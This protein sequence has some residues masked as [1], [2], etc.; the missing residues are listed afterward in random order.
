MESF[1]SN[2]KPRLPA[3]M[4]PDPMRSN[5]ILFNVLEFSN[6]IIKCQT[7]GKSGFFYRRV[8]LLQL[9]VSSSSILSSDSEVGSPTK[10]LDIVNLMINYNTLRST[11]PNRRSLRNESKAG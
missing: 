1:I 11:T 3:N 5:G 8:R 7:S 10:Y 2:V 9:S 6:L 4:N